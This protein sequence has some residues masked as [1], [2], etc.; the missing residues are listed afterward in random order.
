LTIKNEQFAID[1][2]FLIH[3][4]EVEMGAGNFVRYTVSAGIYSPDLVDLMLM[5]ARQAKPRPIWRDDEVLDEL[6]QA[7]ESI[8]LAEASD[9]TDSTPPYYFSE[10]PAEAF[11][12]GFGTF[13]PL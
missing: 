13:D 8:K 6:L 5:L 2:N 1:G 3:R 12:W 7:N 9:E 4:V 11:D 10:D